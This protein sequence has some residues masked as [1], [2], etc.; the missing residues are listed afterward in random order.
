MSA[1][2]RDVERRM[3]RAAGVARETFGHAD[4]RPGQRAAMR[5]V[6]A[7]RD[8]LLVSATGSGKSLVYQVTTLVEA[9]GPRRLTVIGIPGSLPLAR[10][11]ELG[12]A[13][14]SFGPLSQR[15]ALTALAKLV[16]DVHQGGGVAADTR[17]LN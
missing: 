14:V 17:P 1:T 12:V 15:V 6:L 13:R 9:F 5:E 7:G 11:A 8:V 4:L 10:L 2:D 3:A 16:E